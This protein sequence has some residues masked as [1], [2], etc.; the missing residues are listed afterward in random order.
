MDG[1]VAIV[2]LAG[3]HARAWPET[4]PT[5]LDG[6]RVTSLPP[7]GFSRSCLPAWSNRWALS[8]R[9]WRRAR[10]AG[11]VIEAGAD[12]RRSHAR[13]KHLHER[14]LPVGGADRRIAGRVSGRPGNARADHARRATAGEPRQPRAVAAALG[15][16]R[17]PSRHGACR[18]HGPP[19]IAGAEDGEWLTC[20]FQAPAALLGQMAAKGSVAIDGVSLTVVDVTAT[21]FS[22]ALIPHTL[23]HTTLGSLAV[24]DAVNLETDLVFKYVGRWLETREAAR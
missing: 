17:G 5:I 16:A 13:R 9:S 1:E 8:P 22:V 23:A 4:R 18:W 10:R 14:L 7:P 21:A 20:F 6:S 19:R 11:C 3:R 2:P 24:G 12:R 15:S